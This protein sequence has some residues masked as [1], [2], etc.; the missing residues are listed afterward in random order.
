M[1]AKDRL[2]GCALALGARDQSAGDDRREDEYRRD[3]GEGA[4]E[5]A[6]ARGL[7]L[8]LRSKTPEREESSEEDHGQAEV[9][10]HEVLVEPLLDGQP[11]QA[12][13]GEDEHARGGR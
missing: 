1:R 2:G 9:R 13:L 4:Q 8:G 10:G 11:A 3:D 6:A 7:R 5:A 12:R